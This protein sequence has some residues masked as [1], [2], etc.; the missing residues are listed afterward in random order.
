LGIG[1]NR[2]CGTGSDRCG[3]SPGG[4]PDDLGGSIA[5]APAVYSAGTG[6]AHVFARGT[7][8][9]LIQFYYTSGGWHT[10]DLGTV[11]RY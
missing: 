9:H 2:R 10:D 4:R 1:A 7:N 11:Y 5:S 3:R 8:G 6:D